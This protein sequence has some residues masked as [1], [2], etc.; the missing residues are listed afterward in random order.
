MML[1]YIIMGQAT[2]HRERQFRSVMGIQEASREG[3]FQEAKLFLL[4]LEDVG[5]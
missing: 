5:N 2:T 1:C 3:L 4:R